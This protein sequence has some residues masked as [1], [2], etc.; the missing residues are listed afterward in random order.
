MQK[1]LEKGSDEWLF[2]QDYYKFRQ[3]YYEADN[4]EKWFEK[5]IQSADRL[6][7]KYK[8]VPFSEYAKQLILAHIN[9]VDRRARENIGKNG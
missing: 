9:D 7:K 3:Q 1:R 8:N 4:N 6:Y 5:L 2:F